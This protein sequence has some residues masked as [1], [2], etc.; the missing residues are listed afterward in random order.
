[1]NAPKSTELNIGT[2]TRDIEN[3][4]QQVDYFV[5][6][7]LYKRCSMRLVHLYDFHCLYQNLLYNFFIIF[8]IIVIK[9]KC[10][11]CIIKTTLC[12]LFN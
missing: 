12:Y 11:K 6:I 9:F 10:E 1:M 8:I 7:G 4:F 5:I 3:I 2:N